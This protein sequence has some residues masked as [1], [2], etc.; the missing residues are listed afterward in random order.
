MTKNNENDDDYEDE[1]GL[2][3]FES[4]LAEYDD[5]IAEGE[6]QNYLL[7]NCDGNDGVVCRGDDVLPSGE[8]GRRDGHHGWYN[9]LTDDSSNLVCPFEPHTYNHTYNNQP[10]IGIP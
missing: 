4:L 7:N 6:F 8:P 10:H 3:G 2:N 1:D 5:V 9:T